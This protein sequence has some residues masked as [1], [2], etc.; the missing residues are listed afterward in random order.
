MKTLAKLILIVKMTNTYDHCELYVCVI[1][2]HLK[3]LN[4]VFFVLEEKIFLRLCTSHRGSKGTHGFVIKL[5]NFFITEVF[6]KLAAIFFK[7]AAKVVKLS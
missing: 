7:M 4:L 3:F 1:N 6:R 5:C 2:I